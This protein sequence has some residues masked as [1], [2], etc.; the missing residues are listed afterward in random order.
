VDEAVPGSDARVS[1]PLG[2]GGSRVRLK[3]GET[4]DRGNG[5]VTDVL[6]NGEIR[7]HRGR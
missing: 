3:P 6:G 2:D 5:E 4:L 1:V 7:V